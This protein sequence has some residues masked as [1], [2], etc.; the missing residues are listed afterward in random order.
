MNLQVEYQPPEDA[1]RLHYFMRY[2]Q[3]NAKTEYLPHAHEWGQVIFVTRHVLEMNVEGE[4]LLTPASIPIWIPP[5][6]RH[7]SYNHQQ[8]QFRT[9]NLAASLCDGLPRQACLLNADAIV[10]AIMDEF[11]RLGLEQPESPEQWRLCEVLRDRLRLAPVQESYL[12]GSQDK[13]LAPVLQALEAHPGDNTT[14]AEWA[15]RVFT[16]ERTLARRCRQ[17]LHM[18]FSE[19]RQRLRFLHAVAQLGQGKSV[20]AIAHDLGYSSASALIVMFQ[21]QAGTTPDRY[22][23]RLG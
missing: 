2:E 16:T 12:P 17:D 15:A 1:L 11:A 4:R 19:W 10:H 5:R 21:Q 18:S 6:Q 8:A 14:L 22:R 7:A 9:F 3:T 13:F 23:A 20:Q